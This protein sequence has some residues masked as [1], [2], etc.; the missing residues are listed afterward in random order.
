MTIQSWA[1]ISKAWKGKEKKVV[2]FSNLASKN[3]VLA[4]LRFIQFW[5]NL[6]QKMS[7]YENLEDTVKSFVIID[8]ETENRKLS[9]VKTIKTWYFSFVAQSECQC[10]LVLVLASECQL[11]WRVAARLQR[12]DDGWNRCGST[13]G[14]EVHSLSNLTTLSV[15]C[16][17]WIF[18]NY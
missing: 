2:N 11:V 17:V 8:N 7:F 16:V 18:S 12:Y 3:P 1:S 15:S 13:Q 6:G 4:E 9:E 10:Y 14:A 5:L